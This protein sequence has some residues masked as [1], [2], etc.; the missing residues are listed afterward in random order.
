MLE[1]WLTRTLGITVPLLGAPMGGRAGGRLAG[2]VTRAG[3][4]GLIGAARYN[5]S[6]WLAAESA[7]ARE[8][9]GGPLGFGLMT[10]SLA[11]DDSLLDAVLAE[12][13]RVVSLSFGD[14]APYV[15]RVR[16]AGAV[17]I[18][19]INTIDD[20]RVVEA[21]GVDAVVAQGHEAGGHTGHIGTLPLLQE[22][23]EST[24]LPVL[25]AGGIASGRGLA[26]V[27][28]AGAEGALVGTALLA[29]PET[30]GPEYARDLLVAA[31]SSDTV[32]TDVFDRARHQPWP[33]RW[34]GRALANDYTAEWHA[35]GA[36]EETLA[37][38]Y[39]AADPRR[40]V[41]YAGEAAGLVRE[42]RPAGEIVRD[43]ADRAEELLR[44][45]W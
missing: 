15:P 6:E 32:Y 10:W 20:L 1:T 37:A 18:S 43:I 16:A 2:E 38:A 29:S 27:L 12:R 11:D 17:V 19:Q 3:G 5:T 36:D 7:V 31:R 25:A 23:L 44:R 22:V 13:P 21:A 34:G 42:Q 4:L 41:V 9:G 26:A 8:L 28:A 35:R 39:D 24:S 45:S 40:G 33:A 14:P 30:V